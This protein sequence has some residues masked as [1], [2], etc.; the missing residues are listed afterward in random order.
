M[1][2]LDKLIKIKKEYDENIAKQGEAAV[3]EYLTEWFDK[4]PDVYGIIWSQYT[5]YFNDG[6]ECIFHMNDIRGFST[7]E[8][9]DDASDYDKGDVDYDIMSELTDKFQTVDDI[10]KVVFGD[11]VTV[12][13]TRHE[14]TV[15]EC[16]HD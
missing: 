6:D 5:P 16:S 15:D 7:E 10:F 12:K 9:F 2:S 14:F 13:V 1:K 11:H 8:L 3:K 4:H